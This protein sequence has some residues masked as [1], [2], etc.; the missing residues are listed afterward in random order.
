MRELRHENVATCLGLFVAPGVSALVLEHCA[1]GSLEDLLQNEA[2]RLDWTFQA[3][4]LLDLIRV[5]TS[6]GLKRGRWVGP[7]GGEGDKMPRPPRPWLSSLCL[8]QVRMV[9]QRVR[10]AGKVSGVRGNSERTRVPFTHHRPKGPPLCPPLPGRAVPAP[11]AFPTRPPQ[12]PQL[13]GGRAL[14]AEGHGPRLRRA[15]GCSAGPLPAAR[16]GRSAQSGQLVLRL[17]V[18]VRQGRGRALQAS[19]TPCGVTWRLSSLSLGP[20]T[21]NGEDP[22]PPGAEGRRW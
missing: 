7:W 21:V 20:L 11:S 3:S 5:R 14:C 16:P 18:L 19:S 12:V 4:L 22:A 8:R 1:R 10:E 2:L 17:R 15:P 13:C 9:W 6:L